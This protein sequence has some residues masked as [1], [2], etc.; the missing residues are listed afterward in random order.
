MTYLA[1]KLKE[2]ARKKLRRKIRTNTKAKA[3]AQ[4]CDTRIIIQKSNR[5]ISAQAID[6]Q[7]NVI[8]SISD[9]T[10]SWW[11]KKENA[12]KA[13]QAFAKTLISKKITKAVFDRN[14]NLYHGRV[15]AFTDWL[16]E[17]GLSI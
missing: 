5:F 6:L 14:G 9:K 8:A 15:A 4:K 12:N 2:K 13:G 7:G 1:N 11:S 10:T 17:W 16:R 3:Q